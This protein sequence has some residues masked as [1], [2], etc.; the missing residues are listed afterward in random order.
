[1]WSGQDPRQLESCI[2][3]IQREALQGLAY[4]HSYS[5]IHRDIKSDNI[6]LGAGGAV[7]LGDLGVCVCV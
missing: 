2:A 3:Y 1:M 7:K 4:L 6:L 5:R